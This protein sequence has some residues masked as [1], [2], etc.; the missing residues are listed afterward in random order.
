L[1]E[2]VENCEFK[3]EEVLSILREQFG[4]RASNTEKPIYNHARVGSTRERKTESDLTQVKAK[5]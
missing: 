4:N 2:K 5:I 1:K 3:I